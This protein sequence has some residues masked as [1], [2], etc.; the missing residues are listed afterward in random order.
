M[1]SRVHN[2][3]IASFVSL[4][5]ASVAADRVDLRLLDAVKA[6]NSTAVRALLKEKIDVNIS[7]GDGATPLHWAIRLDDVNTAD[8]LIRAGANVNASNVY[9][10]TPLSLACINRNTES[11]N[12]L[13]A[14]GADAKAALVTGETVLMTCARTGSVEA[15]QVLLEHGADVNAKESQ[16]GQT[17]LMWA[18]ANRHPDVVEVLLEHK[19][20]VQMRTTSH[21]LLVNFGARRGRGEGSGELD[22][23]G[24]TPLLFAARQGDG[25]SARMLLDAGA[26]VNDRAPDG[27]SALV[28][29]SFS[30]NRYV[31]EV[32]LDKGADVNADGAG[33]AALHAAVLRGD[34]ELVKALL[35]HGANANARLKHGSPVPR[36]SNHWFLSGY[37]AGATPFLL[38]AKYNESEIMRVLVAKGADPG[39]AMDDGTT[40]L[41]MAAGMTWVDTNPASDRRDRVTPV[42]VHNALM[43]NQAATLEDVKLAVEFGNDVNAANRDGDTA[44]HAAAAHGFGSVVQFLVDKG[45]KM[46]AKNKRGKTPKDLLCY[47]ENGEILLCPSGVQ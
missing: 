12:K 26:I 34:V 3:T 6:R 41:M 33:Y 30:G 22:F 32:L 14:A 39:Q 38:A 27:N 42:E 23:G 28:I 36:E 5:L 11:V 40:P 20:D 37:L 4:T 29:A 45:G 19:A 7:Q 10:V 8:L 46:D 16:H 17:A 25:D 43:A 15:A 13:V 31:A 35:R 1:S 44:L 21:R 47:D 9:G 2:L 24:F 18:V